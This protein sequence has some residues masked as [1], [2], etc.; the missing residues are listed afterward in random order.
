[1]RV[2]NKMYI[3]LFN[4]MFSQFR[5]SL[6][7][8]SET[9]TSIMFSRL[10]VLALALATAQAQTLTPGLIGGYHA[11]TEVDSYL[12]RDLEQKALEDIMADEECDSFSAGKTFYN[13]NTGSY[14][15]SIPTEPLPQSAEYKEYVKWAGGSKNF[16]KQWVTAA[17]NKGDVAE[18]NMVADFGAAFPNDSFQSGECV[19]FEE[20]VKKATSYVFNFIETVQLMEAAIK[21]A[22]G[23][24][25]NQQDDCEEALKFWDA[26]VAIYVGSLEGEKGRSQTGGKSNYALSNKRCRNFKNCGPERDEGSSKD[27]ISPINTQVLAYFSAGQHATYAGDWALMTDYKKLISAKMVVPWIQGTLR[28]SHRLSAER[29]RLND[30]TF[31]NTNPL[32]A[33]GIE[34]ADPDLTPTASAVIDVDYSILDKEVGE[35]GAFALGAVPKLWAC[36]KKAAEAV[37]PQVAPGQGRAGVAPVNFQLVKLA[38]ECNYKCLLTSCTEVGS[39]YDGADNDGAINPGDSADTIDNK[40]DIRNGAK[41]CNDKQFGTDPK[42]YSK[43]KRPNGVVNAKCDLLKGNPGIPK[44]DKLEY[45][46][47]TLP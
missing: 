16:H 3:F 25:I 23:G 42:G 33:N 7:G 40:V 14:L 44:R 17:F 38:F 37:W 10:V 24:C 39:L 5:K 29:S 20:S 4:S 41:Q 1:L 2:L 31:S 22:K 43:C 28:Y 6:L 9:N 34:V 21:K 11:V 12:E 47:K 45:F 32:D 35:A 8:K 19:G 27:R 18:D 15:R 30:K 46:K 13:T 36:S 26:A